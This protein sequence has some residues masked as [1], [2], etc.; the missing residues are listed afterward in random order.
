MGDMAD[1]VNELIEQEYEDRDAWRRGKLSWEEAYDRGVVDEHG[2]E[3]GTELKTKT[4]RCCGEDGLIWGQYEGKW[5]LF[6]NN[7]LHI[8]PINPLRRK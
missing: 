5:R 6:N 2:A 8:C 1:Y 7:K 3:Y 4:C